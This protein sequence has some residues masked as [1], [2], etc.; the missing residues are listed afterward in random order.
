MELVHRAIILERHSRFC[1]AQ[2]MPPPKRPKKSLKEMS[3]RE[4]MVAIVAFAVVGSVIMIACVVAVWRSGFNGFDA[5]WSSL[6]AVVVAGV[7]T[8]AL[9]ALVREWR[10]RRQN[11]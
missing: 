3:N 9:P 6:G 7:L 2:M 5:L 8:M 10:S 4:L 1:F 11:R